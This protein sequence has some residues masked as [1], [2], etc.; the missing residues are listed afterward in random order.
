MKRKLKALIRAKRRPWMS[1]D[2]FSGLA[3]V[4]PYCFS[5]SFDLWRIFRAF[6]SVSNQTRTCYSD[7]S[8]ERRWMSCRDDALFKS[9]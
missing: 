8:P 1:V 7:L 9:T 5:L 6:I 2:M 4:K 3:P